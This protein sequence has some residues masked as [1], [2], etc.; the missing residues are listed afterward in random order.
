MILARILEFA[1]FRLHRRPTQTCV[2][3]KTPGM[4]VEASF[5]LSVLD[6]PLSAST[7]R[8]K[9]NVA[10]PRLLTALK[11]NP[12]TSHLQVSAQCQSEPQTMQG[13]DLGVCEPPL[14]ASAC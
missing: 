5:L 10:G 7:Y 14:R 9:K 13:M 8:K 2:S 6:E 11:P 12:A 1:K 3:A 4:E